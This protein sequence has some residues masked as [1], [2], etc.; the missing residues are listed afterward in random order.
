MVGAT[1]LIRPRDGVDYLSELN[2]VSCTDVAVKA[3][4]LHNCFYQLPVYVLSFRRLRPPDQGRPTQVVG[5]VIDFV[6]AVL[7]AHSFIGPCTA[8][9][10]DVARYFLIFLRVRSQAE[11]LLF[12]TKCPTGDGENIINPIH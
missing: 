2:H 5:N 9:I 1:G 7:S 10:N 11:I 8:W 4:I 12:E 3:L 6:W